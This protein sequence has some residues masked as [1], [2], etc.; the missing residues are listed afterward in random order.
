[1]YRQHRG[2][3][4]R[5]GPLDLLQHARGRAHAQTPAPAHR[6]HLTETV[7]NERRDFDDRPPRGRPHVRPA[8]IRDVPDDPDGR[9]ARISAEAVLHQHLERPLA[10][11]VDGPFGSAKRGDRR[12]ARRAERGHA[13]VQVVGECRAIQF[14]HPPVPEAVRS[15][16]VAGR[17]DRP[18]EP[19]VP[20]GD[21][22]HDEERPGDAGRVE[23]V[24]QQPGGLFDAAGK[25]RPVLR[26]QR[27]DAADVKPL[28]DVDGQG[29]QH[30]RSPAV[31][32][33]CRCGWL[34]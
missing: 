10:A 23:L 13:R 14:V 5:V 8:R 21:P 2:P 29:I 25:L 17:E 30:G 12:S 28:L 4:Q 3:A 33:D 31:M 32:R 1:M 22:A 11:A 20:L 15:H 7:R 9:H 16:V 24:E 19:R 34:R 26:P 27:G 18:D 6:H